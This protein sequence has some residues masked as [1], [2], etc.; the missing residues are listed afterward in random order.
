TQEAIYQQPEPVTWRQWF[1]SGFGQWRTAWLPELQPSVS[2]PA[3]KL[4]VEVLAAV[5]SLPT[6]KDGQDALRKLWQAA[7]NATAWPAGAKTKVLK[8]FLAEMEFLASTVIAPEAEAAARE[9]MEEDWQWVRPQMRTL[10]RLTGEFTAAFS[11]AK[12]ELGGV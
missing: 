1:A 5:P 10:L 9:P 11:K 2:V 8:R 12:R 7:E 6:L 4:F 3:V